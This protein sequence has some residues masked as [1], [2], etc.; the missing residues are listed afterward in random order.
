M[1][2]CNPQA[3]KLTV[4]SI[5]FTRLGSL[6]GITLQQ[7]LENDV[8]VLLKKIKEQELTACLV[9]TKHRIITTAEMLNGK[10]FAHI[11][12]YKSIFA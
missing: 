8:T 9:H 2:N 7:Y 4:D 10:I 6:Q 3:L 12:F 5:F 1:V 11:L